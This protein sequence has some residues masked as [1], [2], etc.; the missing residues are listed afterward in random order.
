MILPT[1]RIFL[2]PGFDL[3]K[4]E[5]NQVVNLFQARNRT[6]KRILLALIAAALMSQALTPPAPSLECGGM[7][8]CRRQCG[9][10]GGCVSDCVNVITCECQ[11]FCK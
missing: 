4:Q 7:A 2:L 9:C 1:F 5:H 8:M 10:G 6:M 3:E 11:C